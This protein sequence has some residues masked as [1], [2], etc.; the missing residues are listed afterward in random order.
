M[1]ATIN[2]VL[3][4]ES[5]KAIADTLDSWLTPVFSATAR[6]VD[7]RFYAEDGSDSLRYHS[8]ETV[9]NNIPTFTYYLPRENYYHLAVVNIAGNDQIQLTGTDHSAS[10]SLVTRQADTLASQPTAVFTARMPIDITQEAEN[11]IFNVNLYMVSSAVAL[12][13]N[14]N[15][16][17]MQHIE[18][19]L[20]GTASR[21]AL[22][23]STFQFSGSKPVRCETVTER[24]FAAIA[25]PSR[26]AAT[27][28]AAHPQRVQQ[29]NKS[30]WQLYVYVTLPDGS[31]TENVLSVDTPLRA[32]ELAILRCDVQDDG[33][34]EPEKNAQVGATVTVDWN[35]GTDHDID[36]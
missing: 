24:C 13:L 36:I 5:D 7:I 23:D 29:A 32:G 30:L 12:V 17:D 2:N 19:Y 4:A 35:S 8:K 3:R 25:F 22:R 14:E 27:A 21:F 31:I 20:H 1:R 34:L 9:K 18:V 16:S 28:S 26:D 15:A 6:D 11:Y 33:S 10:C